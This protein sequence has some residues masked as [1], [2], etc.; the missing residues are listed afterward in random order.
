MEI[1]YENV[2]THVQKRRQ[3]LKK[4]SLNHP[5][6]TPVGS[7]IDLGPSQDTILDNHGVSKASKGLAP[8]HFG[9]QTAILAAILDSKTSPNGEQNLKNV[10][11][12]NNMTFTSICSWFTH[13]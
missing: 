1:L 12:K 10:T 6:S 11:S 7:K 2:K 5:K 4:S 9:A 3:I 8:L 13:D